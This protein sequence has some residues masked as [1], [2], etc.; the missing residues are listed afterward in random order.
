[1]NHRDFEIDELRDQNVVTGFVY[2]HNFKP[3]SVAPFA[4]KDS[5]VY[6]AILEMAERS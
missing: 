5:L 1:M 2:N 3:L 4:K 6:R